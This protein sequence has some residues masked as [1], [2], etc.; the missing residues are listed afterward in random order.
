MI[1]AIIAAVSY[2]IRGG[3]FNEYVRVKLGKPEFIDEAKTIPWSIPNGY[4]RWQW[5]IVMSTLCVMTTGNILLYATLPFWFLGVTS[6]YF[7]GFFNLEDPAKRNPK[8]YAW[9][10]LRGSFIALPYFIVTGLLHEFVDSS[11]TPNGLPVILGA[12]LP[13]A[14]LIGIFIQGVVK[15]RWGFSQI[16]EAIVG[17]LIGL[18]VVLG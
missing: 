7:G 18:G 2:R 11:V 1:E 5:A 4:I 6:G 3:G 8:N 16:G 14:Y 9:L 10:A 15:R 13:I 17:G 12:F